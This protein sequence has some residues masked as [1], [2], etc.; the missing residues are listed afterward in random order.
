ML[1]IRKIFMNFCH[2]LAFATKYPQTLKYYPQSTG[3]IH[4]GSTKYLRKSLSSTSKQHESFKHKDLII[5]KNP[6]PKPKPLNKDLVF[7]RSFAPH[8][9]MVEWHIQQGWGIPKIVPYGP[10]SL[11]PSCSVFHY[12]IE[13]FEGTKAYKDTKGCIRLFRPMENM[14]RM[15]LSAARLALPT[16]DPNEFLECIK[17]L[18]RLDANYIP[19]EKGYSLYIR[20]TFI[21]TTPALGVNPPKDALLYV[22]TS[23]VG[24]YYPSG[25]KPVSL[26]ADEENVRAWP[27]GMGQYKVGLNYAPGILP[28]VK[29]AEKGYSQI[30]WLLN[31]Y[32]TEVGTMN[33]FLFW[34]NKKGERELI[35]P[36]LDGTILP[37]VTRKSILELAQEWNEFKVTEAPFTMTQVVEALN[38]GRII[39]AFGAGTAAVVSPD[40]HIPLGNNNNNSAGELTQRFWDTILGIQYGEIPKKE[41]SIVI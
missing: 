40:Y 8:M 35:T 41:W 14:E 20:P 4:L 19:E 16:F 7:G 6:N 13:C 12:G 15:N 38:E 26:Y 32:L 29:A 27:G 11:E 21:A 25:F 3:L 24:P 5:Q 36:P 1:A 10:L 17:S 23:P 9:F 37:G 28:Q 34:I 2:P 22:I 31:D 30:L 39:E 33:F 18:V